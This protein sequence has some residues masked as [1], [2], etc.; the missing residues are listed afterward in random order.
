[1][2]D[3]RK[4]ACTNA[5]VTVSETTSGKWRRQIMND[6]RFSSPEELDAALRQYARTR[7][8]RLWKEAEG[9]SFRLTDVVALVVATLM[10]LN[11]LFGQYEEPLNGT[12]QIVFALFM[13]GFILL[14]RAQAQMKALADLVKHLER[15][16][17]TSQ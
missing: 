17:E 11:G 2:R 14:M 8:E 1:M 13:V 4:W 12:I 6:N 10:F 15:R 3:D 16:Q 9:R 5:M 7:H